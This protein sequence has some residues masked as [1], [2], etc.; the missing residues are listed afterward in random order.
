MN[1][2]QSIFEVL[3]GKNDPKVGNVNVK[4]GLEVGL[5][6]G[7][8]TL[9]NPLYG[10]AQ[11]TLPLTTFFPQIHKCFQNYLEVLHTKPRKMT[12]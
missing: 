12:N 3:N 9:S 8:K 7:P 1:Y 2:L 11:F 10:P 4:L 6:I 5:I